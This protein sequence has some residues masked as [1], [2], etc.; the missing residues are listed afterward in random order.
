MKKP[1]F[2]ELTINEKNNGM[3][4]IQISSLQVSDFSYFYQSQIK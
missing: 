3:I 1:P 4:K 2:Y